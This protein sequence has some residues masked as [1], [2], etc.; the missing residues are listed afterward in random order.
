MIWAVV[1]AQWQESWQTNQEVAGS[2][3]ARCWALLRTRHALGPVKKRSNLFDIFERKKIFNRG[4][5][6]SNRKLPFFSS[7]IICLL[8]VTTIHSLFFS[9]RKLNCLNLLA[10][11]FVSRPDLTS[12]NRKLLQFQRLRIFS[13]LSRNA[14]DIWN[15]VF[16]SEP[17]LVQDGVKPMA[18]PDPTPCSIYSLL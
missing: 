17:Q 8:S 14:S 13:N 1:V 9:E 7:A 18:S 6:I 12:F 16:S 15:Y 10:R 4:K 11:N 3:P 5:K 2:N